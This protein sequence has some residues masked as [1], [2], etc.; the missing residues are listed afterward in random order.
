LAATA[1]AA[2]AANFLCFTNG[3]QKYFSFQ[4]NFFAQAYK[5]KIV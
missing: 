5:T 4:I 3:F 1:A 2:A